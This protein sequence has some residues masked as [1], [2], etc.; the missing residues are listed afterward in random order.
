MI[1][2]EVKP[3]EVTAM[4]ALAGYWLG[5]R[6]AWRFARLSLTRG[7]TAAQRAAV[8]LWVQENMANAKTR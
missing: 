6:M 3:W 4:A 8:T 2:V 7:L 1:L 5:W